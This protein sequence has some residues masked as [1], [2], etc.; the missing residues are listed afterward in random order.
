MECTCIRHTELPHT[1]TFFADLVYHP[2]RL[3]QF[4]PYTPEDPESYRLSASRI[5]YPDDRRARLVEILRRQGGD[6]AS[7]DLLARRGT[8][9]V[10]T[11]QQ[12]GLFSGP[13]YTIYKAL[14]AV[15][16]A[17]KLTDDGLSAV[18]MFWLA[19][20]DH[21]FPEVNHV[22]LFDS[23]HRPA[24]LA[25]A[26]GGVPSN[27]PVGEVVIADPPIA[28]LRNL[29]VGFPFGE[30]VLALVE[31]AYVPGARMGEAFGRLLET[32]LSEF[33]ILQIDPMSP[34]IRELAAPAIRNAPAAAPDLSA[35]VLDRNQELQA[36]G[37]HAQVHVEPGTSFVF[38]LEGGRRITL[39]RQDREYVAGD[40]RFSTEELIDRADQLSPNALLRP[41]IQDFMLPTVAYIGGPAELAY[42]AQSAVIYEALLGRMPVPVPRAGFTLLNE[43]SRK[44]MERYRLTLPDFFHGESAL[45][46]KVAAT[47]V[48]P[49]MAKL[50]EDAETTALERVE[51][52]RSEL[53]AFDPTLAKAARRSARKIQ[54]QISKLTGKIGREMMSR[55]Q[56]A[57]ADAAYLYGLIYPQKHLQERLYS[58]LPFVARHG[59]TLIHDLYDNVHLDCSDHRLLVI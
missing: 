54:A 44:L 38:L 20:E 15:K 29:L 48:P 46:N 16:L 2:D 21:D 41:V 50:V 35:A 55:D 37:Y 11:G 3:R 36:A 26:N 10:V 53:E 24:K 17:R 7:I 27:R 47:L 52:L 31:Q 22:W 43:R 33:G 18:P 9:A 51:R 45:R 42:L 23:E 34:A 40:R 39:R 59:P 13:A 8:T 4:L 1:S 32:L 57:A 5:D 58:I 30:E 56:R 12:V 14:T 49:A 25:L 19:T 28:E 6:S